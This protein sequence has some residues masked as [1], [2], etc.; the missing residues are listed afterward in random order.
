MTTQFFK[1]PATTYTGEAG[2]P[3]R[4]KYNDDSTATPRRAISSTKVDGD[5]NYLIDAVNVLYD[6]AVTSALPDGSVTNA[7]LANRGACSVIGRSANSSGVP[8]DIS[9]AAD[10]NV[11]VRASG[12][13][14]FG[15]VATAGITDAAVTTV[16][17]ADTNVT[18]PKI[19]NVNTGVVLGRSSAGSGSVQALTTGAG[20]VVDSGVAYAAGMPGGY[21]LNNFYTGNGLTG[22]NTVTAITNQI[23]YVPFRVREVRTFNRIGLTVTA[24]VAGNVRMGIYNH[25]NGIPTT[26][27]LDA[28]AASTATPGLIEIAISQSLTPGIYFYAC[29][30]N[31]TPTVRRSIVNSSFVR[32]ILGADDIA[33]D[34]G[35]YIQSFTY[36]ALPA[37]ASSLG[38]NNFSSIVTMFLRN[39]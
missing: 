2:L 38:I 4:T 23:V 37:S 32:E 9:A 11:L 26:L 7:K 16:K 29:V 25:A 30:F 34:S 27:L 17:I 10:G 33:N 13:L 14:T 5:I 39:V 1:R 6:T 24:G 35:C 3:N 18:F 8:A 31:A 22:G 15:T 28:G 21:A 20:L 19:Q 36:G 12:A